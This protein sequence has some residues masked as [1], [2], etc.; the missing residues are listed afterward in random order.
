MNILQINTVGNSGS[1]GRIAE[2]IG[3]AAMRRG[4]QSHIACG[5]RISESRSHILRIGRQWHRYPNILWTRAFDS[6]SPLAK[7]STLKFIEDIKK[8]SPDIVHLHNLHGYYL[9][10]PTLLKFLG[11]YG[12]PVVWTLHDCWPLTGHCCYF[13]L[14]GCQKWKSACG[15]CPQK[16]EYP[17]SWALD[18]SARNH[19]EK[20]ALALGIKNL[21]LVPVSEWIGETARKSRLKSCNIRVIRNGIDL[22]IFRPSAEPANPPKK[23]VLFAANKWEPRK[24]LEFV[25]KIAGLLGSGFSCTV[26]GADAGQAERLRAMGINAMGRTESAERLR[27]IYSK[28]SVFA[29]PTMQEALSLVNM[30][31][32]ACGT[33]AVTFDSGGTPETI[34]D[35]RVGSVVP[36]GDAGAMSEEIRKFAEAD[37]AKIS[38][39]CRRAA[40]ENFDAK[41]AF[42][43]YCELYESLLINDRGLNGGRF[44]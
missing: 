2:Q 17:A 41:A 38:K 24:G 3:I 32:I 29:N 22:D 31:A 20:T 26:L 9:H 10:A 36:R 40:V 13:D 8:L 19:A 11:E 16:R 27:E 7:A 18:R 37:K 34:P 5:I 44:G 33:P 4:W 28:A 35:A 30:E 6:D 15:A 23:T 42:A 21:T 43:K 14:C 39:I 1:T 12:R 25:P